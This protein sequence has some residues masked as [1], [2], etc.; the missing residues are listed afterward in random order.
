M[1]TTHARGP[2]RRKLHDTLIE[3]EL[4]RCPLLWVGRSSLRGLHETLAVRGFTIIT[5]RHRTMLNVLFRSHCHR[6]LHPLT[7]RECRQLQLHANLA[8][9]QLLTIKPLMG[10]P[11]MPPKRVLWNPRNDQRGGGTRLEGWEPKKGRL[12]K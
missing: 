2:H 7:P 12:L 11:L 1:C 8:S 3:F 5:P 4:C 6:H 9:R 10:L